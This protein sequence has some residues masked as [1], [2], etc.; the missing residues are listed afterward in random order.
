MRIIFINCSDSG[1]TGKI[2]CDISEFLHSLNQ[3]HETI[4]CSP[5]TNAETIKELKKIKTSIKF[6]QGF[7]R[8]LNFFYGIKYGIAPLSTVKIKKAIKK[9]KPDVVHIHSANGYTV[10]IYSL[11][12]FLS[13]RN[14]PTLI[15]NHAEF[16][17]T[18]NCSHAF[19]CNRWETGCGNC[20]DLFYASDTKLF[21][22]TH[23]AWEKMK[24]AMLNHKKLCVA[25]VSPWVLERSSRSPIM[26]GVKQTLVLN[27]INTKI[28]RPYDKD[29]SIR[30]KLGIKPSTKI[31]LQVTAYF[32][33][34]DKKIK[35]GYYFSELAKRFIGEDICFVVVGKT[36]EKGEY[37]N[38]KVL[39]QLDNQ[40]E[41]ALLYSAADLC[42]VTSP[43]ETFGMVVAESLCCGTPV[44]GFKSGGSES[45]TV[46]ETSDF[47]EF[48]DLDKLEKIMRGKWLD[49]KAEYGLQNISDVA[50]KKYDSKIMAENYLVEYNNLLELKDRI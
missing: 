38:L 8:N 2:I 42:V 28:F 36:K 1:S 16:F 46:L 27:G 37:D 49:F 35:G 24:K 14:I 31:I 13:K 18:G 12:R 47:V 41:L 39:G 4:L 21:D 20:P 43:R 3:G 22:R 17:Y 30:K 19:G 34:D 6:E 33:K 11:M 29:D 23:I 7:Y 15:T 45:I 10:N 25:S 32:S 9:H 48:C 50:Q 40:Q 26:Q 44:V 5:K